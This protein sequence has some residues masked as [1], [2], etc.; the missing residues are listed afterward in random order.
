[1]D[2]ENYFIYG[3]KEL[4]YLK[5]RDIKLGFVIDDLGNKLI[6]AEGFDEGTI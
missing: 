5:K 3:E 4:N 1:M 6:R 2:N